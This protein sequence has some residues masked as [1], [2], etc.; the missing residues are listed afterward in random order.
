M[1]GTQ[2]F[3]NYCSQCTF[4]AN[5]MIDESC[6]KGHENK[7]I[8][9]MTITYPAMAAMNKLGTC[10]AVGT[11]AAALKACVAVRCPRTDMQDCVSATCKSCFGEGD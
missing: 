11:C 3:T 2:A 7:G 1:C 6:Q 4:D 8:V 9:C 10:P 5:G